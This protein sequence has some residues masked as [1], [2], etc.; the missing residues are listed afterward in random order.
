MI[1]S[2]QHISLVA[3]FSE[4]GFGDYVGW[5]ARHLKFFGSLTN[6]LLKSRSGCEN[7]IPNFCAEF[8]ASSELH[9]L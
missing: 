6:P 4:R 7:Q 1:I 8:C 2:Q 3:T 9:S 5:V